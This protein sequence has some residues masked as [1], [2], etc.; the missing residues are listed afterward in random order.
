MDLSS[1]VGMPS[2]DESASA[3]ALD[4]SGRVVVGGGTERAS[5]E[6]GQ[7]FLLRLTTTGVPDTSFSGDGLAFNDRPSRP[8]GVANLA[9]RPDGVIVV[10]GGAKVFDS[11][12]ELMLGRFLETGAPDTSLAGSGIVSF[13][14][15]NMVGAAGMALQADGAIV[16][17]AELVHVGLG[18]MHLGAIRL[19][20]DECTKIGTPGPDTL[21]GT[22]GADVL[23]GLGGNDVLLGKGGNDLLI[24]GP[25]LDTASYAGSG[26]A[27]IAH[28]GTG[29]ATGQGTDSLEGMERVT[30][31]LKADRI[32]GDAAANTLSGGAGRDTLN[33]GG[34]ADSLAGGE[35]NDVLNGGAGNDTLNGGP[36]TDDCNQGAGSGPK[37]SCET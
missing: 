35:G 20:G 15:Q 30:G 18:E 22:A 8:S 5:D 1:V 11:N 12:D 31:G 6:R 2:S 17:A 9:I 23:C 29:T 34:G 4:S 19:F 37:T 7:P 13:E 14:V 21:T 27:I 36:G 10:S 28:L 24:G 26:T 32:T 3:V 25:G 16:L 33:G